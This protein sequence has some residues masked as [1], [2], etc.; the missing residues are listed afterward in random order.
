MRGYQ[1]QQP[2][3]SSS[4]H[5]PHHF[6]PQSHRVASNTYGAHMQQIPHMP[7]HMVSQQQ[8]HPGAPMPLAP[9]GV[10]EVK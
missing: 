9:E 5:Q 7:A 10:E 4:P 3:F 2:Q 1:Q 6:P 8:P